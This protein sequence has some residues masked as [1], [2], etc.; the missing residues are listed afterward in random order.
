MDVAWIADDGRFNE[1]IAKGT[2]GE[3][4]PYPDGLEVDIGMRH[5]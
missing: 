4:E 1:A 3:V 2:L 5:Y